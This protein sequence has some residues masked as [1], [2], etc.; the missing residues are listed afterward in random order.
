MSKNTPNTND[1]LPIWTID[2]SEYIVDDKYLRLRADSCTTPQGG[3]VERYYVLELRDWVN[4]IAIDTDGNVIM[5]KHYRHG[6]RKYLSEFVGGVIEEIDISPEMAARRELEEETG[7]TGGML[8]HVGT[9]YPNPAINTN[10]VHTF[11]AVGGKIDRDQNLETGETITV[12]KISFKKVIEQMSAPGAEYPYIYVAALF[13]ALN[14]IRRSD[15]PALAYLK[16][17]I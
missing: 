9:G 4:C 5:L 11:L 17:L 12:E 10:K 3:K 13:H 2:K 6:V 7:Y 16:K 15:D 14:F 1:D 8:Y